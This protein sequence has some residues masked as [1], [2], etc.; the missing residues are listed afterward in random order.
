M[1]TKAENRRRFHILF[2]SLFCLDNGEY[3]TNQNEWEGDKRLA[4]SE[5][6]RD[7]YQVFESEKVKTIFTP[8]LRL[9]AL[10][11]ADSRIAEGHRL[12]LEAIRVM[13]Q[14][15]SAAGIQ[16]AV[17]LLPTK[18]L[19]FKDAAYAAVTPRSKAYKALLENE[20]LL[21]QKTIGFLAS[22]NIKTIDALPALAA[23]VKDGV[24]PYPWS[25]D[26]HPNPEG[27]TVL[28]EVALAE[29]RRQN[30]WPH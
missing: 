15:A 16:F 4:E 13:N 2:E 8:E 30:L 27:H 6:D 26:G 17:L 19:V 20:E 18:E 25:S 11:A 5:R 22:Q 9:I 7:Y 28:A 3:L 12:A 10:D 24:Q 21:R 1:A 14:K 29:L 23:R